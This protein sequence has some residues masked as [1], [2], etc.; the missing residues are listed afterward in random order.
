MQMIAIH[1]FFDELQSLWHGVKSF[2]KR[3]IKISLFLS[4]PFDQ[5]TIAK[6]FKYYISN[7]VTVTSSNESKRIKHL[8]MLNEQFYYLTIVNE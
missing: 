7:Y 3:G 1:F 2:K 8:K 6:I 4:L 5:M